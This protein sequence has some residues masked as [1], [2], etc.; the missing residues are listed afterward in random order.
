MMYCRVDYL[1]TPK[2]RRTVELQSSVVVLSSVNHM[3]SA[4]TS[5]RYG[6]ARRKLVDVTA[7]MET[8]VCT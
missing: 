7:D 5:S 4:F 6:G 2:G 1:V 3:C 8:R